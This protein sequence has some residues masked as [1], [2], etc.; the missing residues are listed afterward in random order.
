MWRDIK[1]QNLLPKFICTT[2]KEVKK[3]KEKKREKRKKCYIFK[4]HS[5]LYG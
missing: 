5:H 1:D 4:N 2:F 3:K